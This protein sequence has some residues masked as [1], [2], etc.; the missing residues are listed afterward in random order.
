[1]NLLTTIDIPQSTPIRY[2]DRLYL[3]GS[4]FSDHMA[5]MF[6]SYCFQVQSNPTGTLYNPIS[7]ARHLDD[8]PWDVV[9]ITFGTAWVYVDNATGE[10]VD[11]CLKRPAS[12]FTRRQMSVEEVVHLWLER[13]AAHPNKR[14]IFTV[15]PIRHLKDGLHANQLSK[16]ILLQAVEQIVQACTHAEY[17]PSYEIMLDELRDYRFYAADMMHPNETAIQYLWERVATTY[18]WEKDTQASM[19]ELHALYLNQHHRPLHPDSEEHKAWEEKVA[20]QYQQL[21]QHYPWL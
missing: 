5:N 4:C 15:S 3:L 13:I 16:A 21:K 12:D 11:N 14:F 7:V 20:N 10:V 1:M 9:M 17:F 19:H 8:V 2:R 18:L 6:R